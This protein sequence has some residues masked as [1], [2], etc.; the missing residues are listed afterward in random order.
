MNSSYYLSLIQKYKKIITDVSSL[1]SYLDSS[2]GIV[3]SCIEK[4]EEITINGDSVDKGKLNNISTSLSELRNA[5]N[6]V[7]AECKSKIDTYEALYNA[8]LLAERTD[9]SSV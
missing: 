9:N 6:T 1:Y 2:Y 3:N 4:M 8:A 7:I 5:F